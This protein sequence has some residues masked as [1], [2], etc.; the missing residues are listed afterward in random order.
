M[1]SVVLGAPFVVSKQ[2]MTF[3]PSSLF[4]SNGF[5]TSVSG[6]FGSSTERR[7]ILGGAAGGVA[8]AEISFTLNDP[9]L[10]GRME[11]PA[12][13]LSPDSASRFSFDLSPA[14]I[15][16]D[17]DFRWLD[18]PEGAR[19]RLSLHGIEVSNDEI[20]EEISGENENPA[21]GEDSE[22]PVENPEPP[23]GEES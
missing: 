8:G 13:S 22:A 10:A 6:L 17:G 20:P 21:S 9:F 2:T 15:T 19:L 3:G 16:D 5:T 7:L 11:I 23:S 4:R 14:G 18:T 12:L 1:K